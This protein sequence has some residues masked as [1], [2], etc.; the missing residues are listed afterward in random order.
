M[1]NTAN[2][3]LTA[4]YIRNIES[5]SVKGATSETAPAYI[6][7]NPQ[8]A[9]LFSPLLI[10]GAVIL[11]FVIFLGGLLLQII[12][13]TVDLKKIITTLFI[14]L[15]IAST[16]IAVQTV[17]KATSLQSKAAPDEVPYNIEIKEVDAE[18]VEISWKIDSP[19][20]GMIRIGTGPLTENYGQTAISNNGQK[21]R[22][23]TVMV[24][25]VKPNIA[26][27]FEIL[28]GSI[29]YNENGKPIQFTINK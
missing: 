21:S 18:K 14:A 20:I 11:F 15:M 4:K 29:W 3:Q 6:T 9:L 1:P 28:S 25:K 12:N 8:F 13:R 24:E 26:Y 16:P 2:T 27:E 19:R 22:T 10:Y 5:L 23:H 17:F 7:Q